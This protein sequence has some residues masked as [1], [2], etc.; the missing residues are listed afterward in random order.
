[1]KT[2]IVIIQDRNALQSTG[3]KTGE[4]IEAA[5]FNALRQG[6]RALQTVVPGEAPEE[7]DWKQGRSKLLI[8]AASP[9]SRPLKPRTTNSASRPGIGRVAIA[10]T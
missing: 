10:I 2:E 4:G 1:M 3:P 8:L 9:F 7:W 6:L 5:R